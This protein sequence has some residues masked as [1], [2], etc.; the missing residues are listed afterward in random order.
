MKNNDLLEVLKRV[1]PAEKPEELHQRA[2][3]LESLAVQLAE[4]VGGVGGPSER[5]AVLAAFENT[6]AALLE[7]N[8]QPGS[9]KY[10]PE[11]IEAALREYSEEEIVALYREFEKTGGL[12]L[13]QF[14]D[15]L[16]KEAMRHE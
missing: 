6:A 16:E 3:K 15:E 2:D 12:E 4:T 9:A 7:K 13:H 1:A 5:R 10:P 8:G 14:I 11:L